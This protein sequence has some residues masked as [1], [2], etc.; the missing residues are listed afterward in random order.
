[1]NLSKDIVFYVC[2]YLDFLDVF[3]FSAVSKYYNKKVNMFIDK[4][5]Y[6]IVED[7]CNYNYK[8]KCLNFVVCNCKYRIAKIDCRYTCL[9]IKKYIINI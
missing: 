4:N 7:I 2:K 8:Y 6:Y 9:F 1:M 5:Y 3:A